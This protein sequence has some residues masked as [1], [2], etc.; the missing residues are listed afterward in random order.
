MLFRSISRKELMYLCTI[1]E[2]TGGDPKLS[3]RGAADAIRDALTKMDI[4]VSAFARHNQV[5]K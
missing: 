4:D 2:R 1:L 5:E 3:L